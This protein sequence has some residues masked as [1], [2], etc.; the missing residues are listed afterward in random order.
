MIYGPLHHLLLGLLPWIVLCLLVYVVPYSIIFVAF[1]IL[2]AATWLAQD[3]QWLGT[4][5]QGQCPTPPAQQ[6]PLAPDFAQKV[7]TFFYPGLG[8]SWMQ[9]LRY[10]GPEGLNGSSLPNAPL[11]MY[12]VR[13]INPPEVVVYG[14][15]KWPLLSVPWVFMGIITR[16]G[17]A[18]HGIT[19]PMAYFLNVPLTSFAQHGDQYRFLSA[20]RSEANDTRVK[21]ARC[22]V[23]A[24]SSRGASTVLGAVTHMTPEELNRVGLVLLEGAFDTVPSVARARFGPILGPLITCVLTWATSYD[25]TAPTPLDLAK[26]FPAK[27]P[28]AFIT[29]EADTVVPMS[30]TLAL[31]D[32]V[33]E[34]RGGNG[35]HVH[36]LIL[37]KSGHSFY[38]NQD[39]EDQTRYR[40]FVDSL[41]QRYI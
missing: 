15:A 10:V 21:N 35:S 19:N 17:V 7:T 39:L 8:G 41:Y 14:G 24:G 28:V 2:N 13:P 38:A 27:V 16:I 40:E 26:F 30:N 3:T 12:S 37:K 32:A 31:R 9:A 4:L 25:P 6:I 36:T 18:L 5:G 11:L 33:V 23:L 20:L 1:G 22:L 29:S 34:A